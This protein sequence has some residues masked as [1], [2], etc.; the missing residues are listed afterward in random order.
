MSA[1][2]RMIPAVTSLIPFMPETP[3]LTAALTPAPAV[4]AVPGAMP[5]AP[6]RDFAGL[7]DALAAPPQ[8]GVAASLLAPLPDAAMPEMVSLPDAAAAARPETLPAAMVAHW[9]GGKN[10]PEP[11]AQL[12]PA[13]LPPAGLVTQ[14]AVQ[15]I[16]SVAAPPPLTAPGQDGTETALPARAGIFS[17]LPL[18]ASDD[19]PAPLPAGLPPGPAPDAPGAP[20]HGMLRDAGPVIAGEAAAAEPEAAP[21][22]DHDS[23]EDPVHIEPPAPLPLMESAPPATM[24][25]ALPVPLPTPAVMNALTPPADAPP[26]ISGLP[27]ARV[28]AATVTPP[29]RSAL[30]ASPV[31]AALSAVA[32]AKAAPAMTGAAAAALPAE[33]EATP[34][35]AL[36]AVPVADGSGLA[37][38]PDTLTAGSAPAPANL[39]AAPLAAAPPAER[40]VDPRAAAANAGPQIESA[41]AQVG[42]IRE[43]LRAARPAMTVQHAEFGAVSIRLEPA[44]PDQWRAVL[45]SRDPGFVPAIHAAL[46]TRAIAAAGD[47]ATNFAGQ[48][49]GSQNG[50]PQNGTGDQ[51][52]G[53]SPNGGQGSSQPYLGQSG[54]RDG[55]AA[56]DHRHP[57]TAAALAARGESEA[58]DT[59]ALAH[60][61][62]GLFA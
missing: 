22:P 49:T 10:L 6:G 9:P 32:F 27:A 55:E 1:S 56:P 62:G 30:T 44:A 45:A 11:G 53:A 59:A 26:R 36:G 48:N 35:P 3:P 57:S 13:T 12:P 37:A 61:P 40:P 24:L 50:A 17:D 16:A 25:A 34:A 31:Q 39:A 28:L 52:Y 47:T 14:P 7:L 23:A 46:E 29:A 21:L 42:D 54:S 38:A 15:P 51:R 5:Q 20:A 18:V 19:S 2:T 60:G 8:T 43:A 41:I 4:P 58:E 33:I